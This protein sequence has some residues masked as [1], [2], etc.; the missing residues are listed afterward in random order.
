M[1]PTS[2]EIR[3]SG[4]LPDEAVAEFDDV[5]VMTTTDVTTVLS[6]DLADQAALLGLL[7]RLRA[8]GLTVVEVRRTLRATDSEAGPAAAPDEPEP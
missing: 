7:A 8:L 5:H 4:T 3:V 2:Y 6:G 1:A